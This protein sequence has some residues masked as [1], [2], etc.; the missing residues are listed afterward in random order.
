MRSDETL[1][2]ILQLRNR[3][4]RPEDVGLEVGDLRLRLDGVDRRGGT[5]FYETDVALLLRD[6]LSQRFFLDRN[7]TP[8][9]QEVPVRVFDLRDRV[10]RVDESLC[11]I[12]VGVDDSELQL[13][14][15]SVH[16]GVLEQGL[17]DGEVQ[18]RK[19]VRII[20]IE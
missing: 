19:V 4:Q 10:G 12:R 7:V 17:G 16:A 1:E 14:L 11:R 6:G 15:R 2:L 13:P 8:R 5:T 9:G 18:R 3:L 20:R